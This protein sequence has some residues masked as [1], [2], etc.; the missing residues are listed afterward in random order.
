[1][2]KALNVASMEAKVRICGAF[3]KAKNTFKAMVDGQ[4]FS[5][6]WPAMHDKFKDQCL[7]L[8]LEEALEHQTDPW[9]FNELSGMKQIWKRKASRMVAAQRDRHREI[10]LRA[11]A[12]PLDQ[13][14]VELKLDHDDIDAY[15]AMR[16]AAG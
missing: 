6:E 7:D 5:M 9:D 11:E 13:L 8:G 12:A 10:V 1:M 4:T 16:R 3:K 14:K 15:L 2:R